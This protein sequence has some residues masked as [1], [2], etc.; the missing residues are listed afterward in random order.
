[1]QTRHRQRGVTAIGMLILVCVFGVIGMAV[2]KITPLYLQHLRLATI[3]DD[4]HD[5]L[6]GTGTTPAGIRS[7]L[8]RHFTVEGLRIPPDEIKITQSRD[9]YQLRLEHESRAPFFG[10]IWFLLVFD[11]QIEIPR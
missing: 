6:G 3:M 10:D 2:L 8:S 11:K 7:T 5:E 1:M 4:V 9:G